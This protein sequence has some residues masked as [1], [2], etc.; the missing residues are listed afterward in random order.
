[1]WEKGKV[2]FFVK[3]LTIKEA[4]GHGGMEAWRHGGGDE[5]K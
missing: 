5:Q 1:L 3:L 2:G 4:W